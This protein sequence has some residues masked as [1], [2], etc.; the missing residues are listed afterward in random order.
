[1][2]GNREF[3]ELLA[4]SVRQFAQK[5]RP[6]FDQLETAA[7]PNTAAEP[8]SRA[9]R[10]SRTLGWLAPAS[11]D[12]DPAN[13][14]TWS[15]LLATITRVLGG[16]SPAFA[17]RLL[18]HHFCLLCLRAEGPRLDSDRSPASAGEDW[19]G[20]E[21]SLA[22]ARFV[23]TLRIEASGEE[24]LLQGSAKFIVGGDLAHRWLAVAGDGSAGR[25]LVLVQSAATRHEPVATLGLRGLGAVDAR[26]PVEGTKCFEIVAGTAELQSRIEEAR[27][28]IGLA[29]LE[30]ILAAIEQTH[31]L[32]STHAQTRRQNGAVLAQIPAVRRHFERLEQAAA[33]LRLLGDAYEARPEDAWTVMPKLIGAARAAADSAIQV[34][35]GGGYIVGNGVERYWRDVIQLG[36]LFPAVS[37]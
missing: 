16:A 10:E 5:Y 3:E 36:E 20:F 30:L 9:A 34:F 27:R 17:A 33:L 2:E 24:P 6:E 18:V 12:L 31:S 35:G 15:R 32:A 22:D 11:F 25:T 8:L 1:M 4:I 7:W 13:K 37:W 14:R 19:L 23:P 28:T 29:Y 21:A 26:L